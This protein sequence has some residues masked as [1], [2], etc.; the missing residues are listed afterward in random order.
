[1]KQ[2]VIVTGKTHE[3]LFKT[4]ENKGYDVLSLP[5]ITQDELYSLS[6]EATGIVATTRVHVDKKLIDNAPYLKWVGRLGSGMDQIDVE[7]AESKGIKC[8]NSPE[9]N[10]NSVAEHTIG[11][12]LNIMDNIHKSADELKTKIWLR[13][14]NRGDELY[15]KTV[16]IIGFGNTGSA[17]AKLL[18]PFEV[19]ILAYDKYKSGF[20]KEYVREAAPEQIFKYADVVTLH[21]PLTDET[22]HMANDDFFNAFKQPPY[23]LNMCRGKVVDTD[24]LIR[25][26]KHKK[27]KAAAIDVLE[28]EKLNTYTAKEK[29]QFEYLTSQPNVIVTPHIAGYSAQAFYKMA[30]VLMDKLGF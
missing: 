20:A 7:Y 14:E 10:R 27:I 4:L 9:G 16:G 8:V 19:T 11:L 12:L 5:S 25:A 22:F 29:E 6:A 30:K 24:A 18:Q 17:V 26:L 13:E 3:Y 28:N 1:M 15:G 2:K 21:V 23:F